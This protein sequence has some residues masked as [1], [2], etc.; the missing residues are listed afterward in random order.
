[1]RIDRTL[2]PVATM[3]LSALQ[4]SGADTP[5]NPLEGRPVAELRRIL[6][7][8]ASEQTRLNAAFAL[9]RLVP[10]RPLAQSKKRGRAP[11]TPTVPPPVDAGVIEALTSGLGDQAS[12]VRF[13]VRRSLGRAGP[14][15]VPHLVRTLASDNADARAAAADALAWT[16][17]FVNP[18]IHPITPA[19]KA[20]TAALRDPD[21]SVRVSATRA[22]G[23]AGTVAAP[24]LPALIALL[25]DSEW[26]VADAAVVAVAAVDPAGTRSVPALIRALGNEKHDLR[27]FIC[28]E[29]GRMGP[30][31]SEAIPALIRLLD[32][33][34]DSWFAGKAA[35]DALM[36]VDENGTRGVAAVAASVASQKYPFIKQDRLLSL[37]GRKERVGA[38]AAPAIP[39]AL[40]KLKEWMKQRPS[41]WIPRRELVDLLG[42]VGPHT[43]DTVLPVVKELL[44]D[45]ATDESGRKELEKL[46][47][48]LEA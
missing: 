41:R 45:K 40:M 11:I 10:G 8:G 16:S 7:N 34:R 5:T 48:K 43:R 30:S 42:S 18:A 3:L 33:D 21:Y 46:I 44:S 4:A 9:D 47:R 20:L 1:M 24:V 6:A 25:D 23:R 22:L 38:E 36:L 26:A 13:Y 35:A 29:L 28:K 27:E 19:L 17:E 14:P 15:A 2:L 12:A 32:A 37:M 39:Y 31:A